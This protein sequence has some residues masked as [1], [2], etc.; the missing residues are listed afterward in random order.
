MVI[1]Q[2]SKKG[3]NQMSTGANIRITTGYIFEIYNVTTGLFHQIWVE[4]DEG[5][6]QIVWSETADTTS[7]A[8]E[9]ENGQIP[10]GNENSNYRIDI[11]GNFQLLNITNNK[12][13][14]VWIRGELGNPP[15]FYIYQE[16]ED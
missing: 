16:G 7:T 13:Y 9:L 8:L 11:H 4:G 5:A 12:W 15:Q 14:N 1:S 3:F 10:N 6:L 2:A